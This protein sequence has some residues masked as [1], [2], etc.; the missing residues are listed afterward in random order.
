MRL[1][2]TF[3]AELP[4]LVEE[5]L[6]SPSDATVGFELLPGLTAAERQQLL[7]HLLR[8]CS[9]GRYTSRAK[10]AIIELPEDWLRTNVEASAESLFDSVD[11]LEWSNLLDVAS[12]IDAAVE[13]RIAERAARHVDPESKS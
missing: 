1:H 2:A 10:A 4:A 3:R 12:R 13:K 8:L 7:P 9:S 6:K 11:Y 5:A